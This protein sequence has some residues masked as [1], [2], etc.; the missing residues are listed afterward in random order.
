[1][2]KSE[3]LKLKKDFSDYKEEY[4]NKDTSGERK[5]ELLSLMQTNLKERC[6]KDSGSISCLDGKEH[7]LTSEFVED[8]YAIDGYINEYYSED[9]MTKVADVARKGACDSNQYG[10]DNPYSKK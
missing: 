3:F 7:S 4:C 6:G 2:E 10:P 8:L 9:I 1:M 5:R